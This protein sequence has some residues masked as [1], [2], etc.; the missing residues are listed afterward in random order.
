MTEDQ[1]E[2]TVARRIDRV[3]AAFMRGDM[4]QEQYDSAIADI[5]N[6][7]SM[8]YRRSRPAPFKEDFRTY[9]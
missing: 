4:T 6:W 3:D 5:D 7:A 1:I 9:Q 8:E 2:N